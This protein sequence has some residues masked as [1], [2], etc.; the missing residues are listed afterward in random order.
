MCELCTAEAEEQQAETE[1]EPP[2]KVE[3]V[4]ERR[5]EVDTKCR[6]TLPKRAALIAGRL[7]S[8]PTVTTRFA[9][10]TCVVV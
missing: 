5:P 3:R 2:P 10:D 6:L 4:Q 8:W 1:R 7:C 9:F